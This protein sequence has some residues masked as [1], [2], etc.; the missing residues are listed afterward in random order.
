[1]QLQQVV[2]NLIRNAVDAV[3]ASAPEDREVTVRSTHL[4][5]EQV[6]VS[7]SDRGCGIPERV[8][9]DLYEPFFTT[10]PGGL[11]MGLSISRS[12]VQAHGGSLWYSR[13]PGR[14]TTFC[15]TVPVSG[16]DDDVGG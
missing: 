2:L 16:G 1:V 14:G 6:E 10:K 12:I 13:H 3:G 4:G 5:S 8:G 15:F 11:G 7:V 9:D